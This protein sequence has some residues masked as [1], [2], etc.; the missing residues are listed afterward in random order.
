M[1]AL[2]N[3]LA[4]A[5]FTE[6][7]Q[8]IL[9]L[10]ELTKIPNFWSVRTY[11][12]YCIPGIYCAHQTAVLTGISEPAPHS[13]FL[14]LCYLFKCSKSGARLASHSKMC[15]AQ[16][17]PWRPLC[18]RRLHLQPVWTV[19]QV[20]LPGLL[21]LC[22][23]WVLLHSVFLV[24]CLPP[25]GGPFLCCLE[26]FIHP[27]GTFSSCHCPVVDRS[28]LSAVNEMPK[29]LKRKKEKFSDLGNLGQSSE[30]GLP[31]RA[32]GVWTPDADPTLGLD[33]E[34]VWDGKQEQRLLQTRITEEQPSNKGQGSPGHQPWRRLRTRYVQEPGVRAR[35]QG[36]RRGE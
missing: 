7:A 23:P 30:T 3:C 10:S 13:T 24:P 15:Q 14:L 28:H 27:V 20:P 25:P 34:S 12:F 22:L 11:K 18:N 4:K 21:L 26:G 17:C 2:V 5:S 9:S 31:I 36:R 6:Y 29:G 35:G 19:R 33:L 16:R 32:L 1:S 8:T